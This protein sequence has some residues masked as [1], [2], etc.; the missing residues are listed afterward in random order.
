[1]VQL[2]FTDRYLQHHTRQVY[3]TLSDHTLISLRVTVSYIAQ[4][5]SSMS[6]CETT[7]V[8]LNFIYIVQYHHPEIS[9]NTN[10]YIITTPSVFNPSNGIR[11]KTSPKI[12]LMGQNGR[13][14]GGIPLTGQTDLQK[15]CLQ[16]GATQLIYSRNNQDDNIGYIYVVQLIGL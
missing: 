1:M 2:A 14:R 10:A 11:K 13:N 5:R 15:M 9:L 7:V 12:T 4:G 8:K 16:N 6:H 3:C